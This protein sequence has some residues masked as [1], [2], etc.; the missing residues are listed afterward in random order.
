[1]A[2][3]FVDSEPK[4]NDSS[5]SGFQKIVHIKYIIAVY[6][7]IQSQE[8]SAVVGTCKVRSVCAV[9]L[10][11]CALRL[12]AACTMLPVA[13]S[14]TSLVHCSSHHPTICGGL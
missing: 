11:A 7:L 3:D 8:S 2:F 12:I 4:V 14:Q 10:V 13:P 9:S 1:M 5:L 6:I